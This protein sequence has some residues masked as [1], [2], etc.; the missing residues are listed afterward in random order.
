MSTIEAI[1]ETL[2]S[3]L[4]NSGLIKNTYGIAIKGDRAKD[5]AD[6][7]VYIGNGQSKPVTDF[8]HFT[9]S[10]FWVRNGAMNTSPAANSKRSCEDLFS[11]SHPMRLVSVILRNELICDNGYSLDQFSESI[12][13]EISGKITSDLTSAKLITVSPRSYTDQFTNLIIP[14]KFLVAVIDFTIN[15][16]ISNKCLPDNCPAEY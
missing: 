9:G 7:I 14:S 12:I 2:N 10:S 3:R 11:Y 16:T 1:I 6:Y 8:D 5:K 15:Y 4:Q 13:K